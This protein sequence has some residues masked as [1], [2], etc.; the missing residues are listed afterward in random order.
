MEEKNLK[1]TGNKIGRQINMGK[2][3]TYIENQT[4]DK[5][6]KNEN[7]KNASNRPNQLPETPIGFLSQLFNS[8]PKPINIIVA[9]ILLA[10][11]TY[12]GY[13]YFLSNKEE[14][15]KTVAPAKI[16]QKV[17][18][19]GRLY[20]DNR[21]PKLNEVKRL[22]L[23]NMSGIN[24][25]TLDATGKYTFE[26]VKIPINKKLLV[27]VTFND[28]KV[29]PTEEIS[30]DSVNTEDNTIYLPDMNAEK[31]RPATS[32]KPTSSWSIKIIQQVHT[33][34]GDNKASQN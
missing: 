28:D 24:S 21:V 33:G 31:P 8:L 4:V 1:N 30:V 13:Y 25:S 6:S 26:N 14:P 3:S 32:S 22:V 16:Q 9:L 29:V 18:V 15:A 23:K 19:S 34:N 20:I 11:I 17:Y 10:I 5:N 7:M 27:E 12:A 2:N